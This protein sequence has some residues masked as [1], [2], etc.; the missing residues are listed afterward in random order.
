MPSILIT[1]NSPVWFVSIDT[2]LSINIR[3]VNDENDRKK[4]REAENENK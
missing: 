2:M 4:E 3:V 1:I